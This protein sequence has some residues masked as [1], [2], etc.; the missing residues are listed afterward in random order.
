MTFKGALF[1]TGC[2][3]IS[4]C[5]ST[6]GA[7]TK[8]DKQTQEQLESAFILPITKASNKKSDPDCSIKPGDVA[9]FTAA[10]KDSKLQRYTDDGTTKREFKNAEA[11][12]DENFFYSQDNKLILIASD[13]KSDRIELRQ[14]KNLSLNQQSTLRFQAQF[15][16]LPNSSDNKGVTLA[17]IHSDADGVGRPILRLEFTGANELRAVVTDTYEK[18]EGK[19]ENDLLLSFRDG[20]HLYAMIEIAPAGNAMNIYVKN[21]DTGKS[22]FK[23]YTASIK[24]QQKDGDFYFKTGAYLQE[25]GKSP[26]ATYDLLQFTY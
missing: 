22:A 2:I 1:F 6:I 9:V 26:R 10:L 19:S 17:Q 11:F 25:S 23:T 20:H 21:L 16:N 3:F 13:G 4:S 12:C 14:E 15:E 18:G 8:T 7:Q 24:W 5:T